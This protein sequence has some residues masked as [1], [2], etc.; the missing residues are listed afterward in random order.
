MYINAFINSKDISTTVYTV[1]LQHGVKLCL[2]NKYALAMKG[3]A[4]FNLGDDE[5]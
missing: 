2:D 3:I 5:A 1:Q 4:K